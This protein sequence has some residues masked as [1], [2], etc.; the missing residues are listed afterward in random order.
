MAAQKGAREV[1]LFADAVNA[2]I[3][4]VELLISSPPLITRL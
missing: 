4:T 1:L 3:L 2:K